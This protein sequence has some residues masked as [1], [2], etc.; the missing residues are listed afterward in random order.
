LRRRLYVADR[1]FITWASRTAA[2]AFRKCALSIQRSRST[3]SLSVPAFECLDVGCQGKA[4]A[5]SHL[6]APVPDH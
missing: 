4:L 3:R 1:R 6:L 5:I 2:H